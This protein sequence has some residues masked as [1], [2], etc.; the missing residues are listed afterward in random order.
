MSKYRDT[1]SPDDKHSFALFIFLPARH[2]FSGKAHVAGLP[3][4]ET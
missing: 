3:D 1:F 4:F 2:S